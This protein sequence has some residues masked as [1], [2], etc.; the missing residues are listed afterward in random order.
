MNRSNSVAARA[1]THLSLCAGAGGL[2]LGLRLALGDALRTVCYVER[3]AYAAATLVARMEDAALDQ[4]PVW[5]DL[6][7][8]DSGQ[9]RGCVDVLSAGYPCQPWSVAGQQ[10]GEADERDL[11]PDVAR[12]IGESRPAFVFLENVPGVAAVFAERERPELE[13]MGYVVTARL[14]SAGEVGASQRRL[15][16]FAL[17][18]ANPGRGVQPR[19]EVCPG[20][21]LAGNGIGDVGYAEEPDGRPRRPGQQEGAR[22]GRG[23]PTGA[24][25]DVAGAEGAGSQGRQGQ[26]PNG[27]EGCLPAERGGKD[28]GSTEGERAESEEQPGLA[29]S[30]FPPGP[31]DSAAW[32]NVLEAN[33]ALE[34]AVCGVADGMAPRVDRLRLCGNGVVPLAAAYAF[35]TLLA[36]IETVT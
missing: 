11:W 24:G 17:A 33:P 7:T 28:M 2:D 13:A 30:P 18:W 16:M 4:A 31:N 32:A 27:S 26:R 5:D 9:W 35:C 29:P 21:D 3:E 15:R 1:I 10:R 20:R 14:F 6:K 23:E 8:F 25:G 34:P 22:L 36:H 19:D 12:I